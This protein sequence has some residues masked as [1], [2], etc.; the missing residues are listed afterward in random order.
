[1]E[2]IRLRG[3]FPNFYS[4]IKLRCGTNKLQVR[5]LVKL[6]M[7]HNEKDLYI[8]IYIYPG[9]YTDPVP[10]V[11]S[12]YH[13]FRVCCFNKKFRYEVLT[14]SEREKERMYVRE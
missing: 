14:R 7:K 3:E 8:Y 4:L 10:K 1:M 12:F 2:N 11:T 6:D 5:T 13:C 9:I